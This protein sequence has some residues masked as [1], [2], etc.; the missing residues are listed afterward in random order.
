[1]RLFD[2]FLYEKIHIL[3][4]IAITLYYFSLIRG[5]GANALLR[6]SNRG[7]RFSIVFFYA[8][9][10]IIVIGLRPVHHAFGD[11]LNYAR[12]YENYSE[13][14]EQISTSR[15]ALFY[16]FMWFCSQHISVQWFFLIIELLYVGPM[17]LAYRKFL[18]GNID[19]GLLFCLGAFSFFTY[20][21]NGIRNGV[22]LSLVLLAISM[23]KG[24]G[25]EKL[26]SFALAIIAISI[27]ASAAL[28][29]VCCVAAMLI[30]NRKFMFYF[31]A[32]AI[33]VSLVAGNSVANLFAGLGFDDRLSDYI[34]PDVEEDIWTRT[35]FRW[36]FLI[37][38]SAPIILGYYTIIKK[39]VFNSTYLL[40]LGTYIFAN[41]FWIMV[42]RAEFSNR[43][44]YLS[45]F[46][47]PIVLAYPLLN[48]R[49]WPKTQG[50][51]T[52]L[53][54]LGHSAFT[55]FMVLIGG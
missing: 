3:I 26:L 46:L 8:I 39:R 10:F 12:T 5:K 13:I 6:R 45:W 11:T 18:K 54:L 16:L 47:Y 38:S 42:I 50:Q 31:W 25:I 1:M 28:P 37:Y 32:L 4:V 55:L 44:A 43:F 35:G 34:H 15:D 30:K 20:G 41:A 23:I 17:L 27:H 22:A 21:V 29:I 19:I 2:P 9:V 24:R 49:I 14:A 48:L 53:I 7:I 52:A 33:V 51:K 36:D 40:L